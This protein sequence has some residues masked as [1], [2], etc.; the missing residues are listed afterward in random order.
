MVHAHR[1]IREIELKTVITDKWNQLFRACLEI[2]S[3]NLFA[4]SI[5]NIIIRTKNSHFFVVAWKYQFSKDSKRCSQSREPCMQPRSRIKFP[6]G[7]AIWLR[8]NTERRWGSNK[9]RTKFH[10][11]RTFNRTPFIMALK[12][13]LD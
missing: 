8:G 13:R 7:C 9:W 2:N 1:P 4:R 10:S 11:N 3:A 6:R 5:S 12:K